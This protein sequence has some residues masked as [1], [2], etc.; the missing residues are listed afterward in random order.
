[1]STVCAAAGRAPSARQ[2]A[3][4][5]MAARVVVK[6]LMRSSLLS[7]CAAGPAGGVE[8]M[9]G[10]GGPRDGDAGAFG[11]IDAAGGAHGERLRTDGTAHDRIRAEVLDGADA[12]GQPGATGQRDG[13]GADAEPQPFALAGAEPWSVGASRDGTIGPVGQVEDVHGRRADEARGEDGGRTRVQ[14][15]GRGVLLDAAVTE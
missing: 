11:Q 14:L 4:T 2:T 6:N 7:R 8:Q 9:R 5:R 10:V 1:M 3:S 13:L 12:R 15:G